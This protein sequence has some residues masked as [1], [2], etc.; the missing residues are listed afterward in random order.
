MKTPY[1]PAWRARLA[2][3]GPRVQRLRQHSLLH[4][5][6]LFGAWLPSYLLAPAQEGPHSRQRVFTLRRTFWGFLYQVLN[7]ACPCRQVVRQIQALLRLQNQAPIDPDNSAYCQARGRLPLEILQ[8]LR[9]A[10]ATQLESALPWAPAR[11]W[12]LCPKVIDGTTI[13]LPDTPENQRAYPQH[14]GQKPGCGFPLLR[15]VGLFSLAS[16]GLLDY[17]QGNQHQHELAL[18]H[19]LLDQFK[20]GDLAL[21]DRGFSAYGLMGLLLGRGVES[22]FRLH[23]RRRADLRQ[24]LRLGQH[25]RRVT[26]RK[27]ALK[28]PYLPQQL[29]KQIPEQLVVR[30]LRFALR[31]PGFRSQS[32]TLV[33]SLLDS[34]AYPAEQLA[35]LYAQRWRIELWFRDIKTSMGMEQLRCQR[36]PMVHKELEMFLI[37]YNLVRA[38]QVQASASHEVAMERLSFKGTVDA[39]RQ[40]SIAI[41]QARSQKKQRELVSELL[42]VIAQDPLPKRPGRREPRAL[43]RRLKPYPLLNKPRRAYKDI[44]HRNSYWKTHPS[45]NGGLI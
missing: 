22:L 36:P 26:W 35:Q 30:V 3:L 18:L 43:K 15:L 11:G 5:E 37:A 38:L 28:P 39:S 21:A 19:Q 4:L 40:Y 45:K 23:Q 33:T 20:P 14:P 42:Q 32:V 9:Q 29:W 10:M 17:A 27:P 16:G 6:Q 7:P 12:G 1:F 25:D 24:G 13:R 8:R 34:Q 2:A 31:V 44:P 41:A